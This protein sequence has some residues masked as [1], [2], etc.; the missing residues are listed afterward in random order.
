[1]YDPADLS[2]VLA[3]NE[4]QTLRYVMEEKYVQPMALKDR[5]PGDSDQLQRIRNFNKALEQKI[6]D[7][8]ARSA[9]IVRETLE[10][11][12]ALEETTLR[13]LM[14]VD[15]RGQHKNQ[16]GKAKGQLGQGGQLGQDEETT[17]NYY[18]LY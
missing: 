4:D 15:N 1:M 17:E 8:R 3:V 18:D 6:T 9:E 7:T 16:L 13:K 12:P 11:N 2:K 14:I 10:Q 5:K